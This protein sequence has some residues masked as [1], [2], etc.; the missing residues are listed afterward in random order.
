MAN[1]SAHAKRDHAR[2][3]CS[4]AEMPRVLC[5]FGTDRVR[6]LD[7]AYCSARAVIARC[8]LAGHASLWQFDHGVGLQNEAGCASKEPETTRD[9]SAGHED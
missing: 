3:P 9:D 6:L 5:W 7:T 4:K 8:R 1:S 2:L